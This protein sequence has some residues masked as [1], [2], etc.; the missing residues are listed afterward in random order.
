MENALNQVHLGRQ[1]SEDIELSA[2]TYELDTRASISALKDVVAGTLSPRKVEQ[3]C[4][5]IQKAHEEKVDWK[6]VKGGLAKK[7]LKSELAAAQAAFDSPDVYN[8]PEGN[9]K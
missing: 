6:N 8:L 5:G 2:R 3:L 4:A 1:M 9:T 7:L